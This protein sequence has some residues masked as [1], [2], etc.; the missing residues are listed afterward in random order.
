MLPW[1]RGLVRQLDK[2][3]GQAAVCVF[4]HVLLLVNCRM[5]HRAQATAIPADASALKIL[6]FARMP[7]HAYQSDVRILLFALS[8][9]SK[10]L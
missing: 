3:S 9:S 6:T 5:G 2:S 7:L 1:T 8:Y 10:G 4:L